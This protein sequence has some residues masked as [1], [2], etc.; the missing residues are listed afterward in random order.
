MHR[1][2]LDKTY[3]LRKKVLIGACGLLSI[4]GIFLGFFNLLKIE[5]SP[6]LAIFELIYSLLSLLLMFRALNDRHQ[7]W[8]VHLY[9]YGLTALII[10]AIYI[11]DLTSFRFCW[12]LV[13]PI[14][15]F[16][17][18]GKKSATIPTCILLVFS[19]FDIS[20]KSAVMFSSMIVNFTCSYLMVW[21]VSYVYETNRENSER[22]LQEL[23]LLDPLT[24]SYNRLALAKQFQ[25]MSTKPNMS[26]YMLMLDLDYFKEINDSYGHETGD[27]ILK[28]CAAKISLIANHHCTFRIGG[29]EFCVIVET[30]ELAQA[31]ALAESI[32]QQ[33]SQREFNFADQILS[34]TLSIGVAKFETDMTLSH[35]L[36]EADAQ[37]YKAKHLGR[38]RVVYKQ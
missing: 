12:A 17:I 6:V 29:E 15:F 20:V 27:I 16:L 34:I 37:L 2:E 19:L 38:N 4:I 10:F 13:V 23:A 24:Q 33:I 1:I 14:L 30:K 31:L 22:E 36:S 5:A 7:I 11:A 18:L 21:I 35:V 26:M 3:R 25:K 9:V 28:E 8:E 32:R